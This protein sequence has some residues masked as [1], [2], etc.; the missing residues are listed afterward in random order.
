[1]SAKSLYHS[2]IA[3]PDGQAHWAW[4]SSASLCEGVEVAQMCSSHSGVRRI[5]YT[6]SPGSSSSS[7]FSTC[8]LQPVGQWVIE[9]FW[10]V[11]STSRLWCDSQGCPIIT[12]CCP[13][14]VMANCALSKCRL[15]C[16]RAWTSSMMEP[17]SL[18]EPSTLRNRMG[19][20]S[21]VVSSQCFCM[22]FG[23]MNIP[24]D[25]GSKREE[26]AMEAREVREVSSTWRLRECEEV[27]RRT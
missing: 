25:S 13:R 27:F 19:W 16:R 23:L 9:T 4:A 8:P 5:A 1:M 26:V 11:Q 17:C 14:L 12:D 22:K 15:K 7:G 21:G 2:R 18:V 10:A 3:L 20:G 6:A 24:V